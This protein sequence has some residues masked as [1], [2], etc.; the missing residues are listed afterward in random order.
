MTVESSPSDDEILESLVDEL[1]A[2]ARRG[3][4]PDIDGLAARHPQLAARIRSL[5]PALFAIEGAAARAEEE[6]VHVPKRLGRYRIL[7]FLGGGSMGMVYEAIRES[8]G[9]SP[10]RPC[11]L[12]ILMPG[13]TQQDL[14]RFR[15]EASA[16]DR[17][18]HPN[19][20]PI[21][22]IH[23][24]DGLHYLAMD[25]IPGEGVNRILNDLRRLR[26]SSIEFQNPAVAHDSF[27][28]IPESNAR[29]SGQPRIADLLASKPPIDFFRTVA[30]IAVQVADALEHAHRNGVVHR[31]VKPSNILV[32]AKLKAWIADFGL[33]KI[34][35]EESLTRRGEVVGTLRYIAPERFRGISQPPCDIYG[36]GVTLYEMLTLRPAFPQ[37]NAQ[38]LQHAVAF[39]A[40]PHPRIVD[41]NI[42]IE[43]EAIVLKA[44]ARESRQRYETMAAFRDELRRFLDGQ[45]PQ[46]MR[47][48]LR[49]RR[50][51]LTVATAVF[52]VGA[53]LA[54]AFFAWQN[55][56]LTTALRQSEAELRIARDHQLE[57]LLA[58][59][60]DRP[61]GRAMGRQFET[62]DLLDRADRIAR[63][64]GRRDEPALDTAFREIALLSRAFTDL[65]PVPTGDRLP[66]ET[67]GFD[68][69]PD[70]S[71][72][73]RIDRTGSLHVHS[74]G[75]ETP[76]I[77]FTDA[78]YVEFQF[79]PG[80]DRLIAQTS[81]NELRILPVHSRAIP[82]ATPIGGALK[83]HV[84]HDGK[85]VAVLHAD[86]I[87]GCYRTSDGAAES[88]APAP[89][90]RESQ[91]QNWTVSLHPNRPFVAVF[92]S[93]RGGPALV[94]HAE[95][96]AVLER[97][98]LSGKPTSCEWHPDGKSFLMAEEC[99]DGSNFIR[100]FDSTDRIQFKESWAINDV[101]IA[102]AFHPNGDWIAALNRTGI[103]SI[104]DP[105]GRVHLETP[106]LPEG[107]RLR[108][109]KSSDQLAGYSA[110]G[111]LS[112]WKFVAGKNQFISD[113]PVP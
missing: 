9:P 4:R 44:I 63:Q 73:G 78:E 85:R 65:R 16:A 37:D 92:N 86:G 30:N 76:S 94:L 106:K 87:L 46:A 104:L 105:N 75:S 54:T 62:L 38:E 31:D 33:A 23:E 83:W 43:L 71:R 50:P 108:W 99:P 21:H 5:V 58:M 68:F 59:A 2:C 15:Q 51:S 24:S 91:I 41:P 90:P 57:T 1:T 11:A 14:E 27:F 39:L 35:S 69:D 96:G 47:S 101:L 48:S 102:M 77:S 107:V 52:V 36:L 29:E 97:L 64:I 72:Y 6:R 26:D 13:R 79:V 100:R 66:P 32:D 60:R 3:E 25:F 10:E 82:S 89:L 110:N 40:P 61:N 56:K 88:R 49:E 8:N 70:G 22:G 113:V 81:T 84:R 98:P 111:T 93:V 19:I 28:G 12:K 95:T 18:R 20:V 67:R 7:H 112:V 74:S 42:P 53:F 80:S 45:T 103:V 34:E 55:W 17:L 109:S